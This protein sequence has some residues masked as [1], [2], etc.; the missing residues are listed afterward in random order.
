MAAVASPSTRVASSLNPGF[1]EAEWRARQELACAY[2]LFDQLRLAQT[3]LRPHHCARA[4][5]DADLA[6]WL[7][8]W[9][10]RYAK[11]TDWAQDA[12]ASR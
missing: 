6:A 8:R 12:I 10:Q 5:S 9:Q 2:R 3:D 4:G 11:L 1:G 7:K